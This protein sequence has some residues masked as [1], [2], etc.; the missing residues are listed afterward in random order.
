MNTAAMIT[1]TIGQ[2]AMAI[3]SSAAVAALMGVIFHTPMPSAADM[4]SAP[5]LAFHASIFMPQSAS[6]SHRMG[7]SARTN[8]KSISMDG[9]PSVGIQ[10]KFTPKTPCRRRQNDGR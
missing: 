9:L 1:I 7:R 2:M 4:M 6:T 8:I 3:P 5:K 10:E